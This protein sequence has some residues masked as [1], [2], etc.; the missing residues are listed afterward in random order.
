MHEEVEITLDQLMPV[1]EKVLKAGDLLTDVEI[2]L[3][4]HGKPVLYKRKGI[5]VTKG[6]LLEASDFLNNLYIKK[7]D[8]RIV[9][10][11][12]HKKA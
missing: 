5:P 2:Y 12:I 11:G 1:P 9:L 8:A 6:F 7:E 3:V 4:H 10:E